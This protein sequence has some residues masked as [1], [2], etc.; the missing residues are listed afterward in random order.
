MEAQIQQLL[1]ALADLRKRANV[2]AVF[3]KP[4]AAEGRTVIPVAEVTYAFEVEI[5]E[6]VEADSTEGGGG[7]SGGLDVRPV[8]VVEVTPE[9]AWVRPIVDEQKLAFAGA[10]LIGWAVFWV[11]RT[12]VRI[13][14]QRE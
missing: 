8:A 1:D 7:G 14:G 6:E 4:V 10:L 11:A 12:L 9:N 13:F 3:G 5:D 2:D